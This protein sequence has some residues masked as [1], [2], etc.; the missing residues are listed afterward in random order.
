MSES[1]AERAIADAVARGEFDNLAGSGKPLQLTGSY[2]PDW[3]AKD[4]MRR[5]GIDASSVVAPTVALRREA[6][7]FPDSLRDLRTEEAVRTVL[8]DFNARVAADWRRPG[9]GRGSPI[10]ARKVDIDD[11]V[12]A[13]RRLRDA[14]EPVSDG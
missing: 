13:W 10:V 9:V 7:G 6:D 1:A 8:A 3:W 12:A 5:E 14:G 4:L 2:D 11:L